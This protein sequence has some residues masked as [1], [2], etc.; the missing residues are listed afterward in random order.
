[1]KKSGRQSEKDGDNG[2]NTVLNEI[3]KEEKQVYLTVLDREGGFRETR[4]EQKETNY[5]AN[6]KTKKI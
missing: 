5:T 1:V 3:G 4:R 2:E 6:T